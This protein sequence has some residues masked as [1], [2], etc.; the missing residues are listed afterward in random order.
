MLN[1][2]EIVMNRILIYIY[3]YIFIYIFLYIKVGDEVFWRASVCAYK[4]PDTEI[5]DIVNAY[6]VQ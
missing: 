2:P 4:I 1:C 6:K 3:I 5:T